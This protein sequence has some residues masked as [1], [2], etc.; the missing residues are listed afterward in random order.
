[1]GPALASKQKLKEAIQA[2]I[3]VARLNFSHGTHEDH[4]F[5]IQTIHELSRE[6][7]APV[8]LLQ[9]L[10]GP[11]IRLGK[12]HERVIQ[13]GETLRLVEVQQNKEDLFIDEPRLV[14]VL[15]AGDLILV[16][17]G[18]IQ[19]KVKELKKDHVA[20]EV[21]AGGE[22]KSRKGF[23]VPGR[24]LPMSSLTEKDK[25]DLQFG[26]D[27]QV[28][29][30]ALSFVRTAKDVLELREIIDRHE[31]S[32]RVIAKIEMAEAIDHLKEIIEVSDAIMVARG[33]LAIEVGSAR[34]PALQK[35]IIRQCNE[36]G[37]PVITA[38]QMLESM[39][40]AVTPTR[41]E[42]TDVANAVLDG[43]DALML[44]AES[45]SGDHPKK[46]IQTM[47][48]IILEA[49]KS[50][51]IYNKINVHRNLEHIP[52]AI[53][54]SSALCAHKLSAKAIVCLSTTGRTAR[55]ISRFRPQAQLIA[56]TDK[57]D[58]L[59]SLELCWGVQTLPIER[60]ES[61]EDIFAKLEPMLV[62]IG[63][64]EAGDLVVVTLG[65]PVKSG[66]KTNSMRVFAVAG[67]GVEK[68]ENTGLLRFGKHS[69]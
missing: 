38:T 19:L 56:A 26:L 10:Q 32:P 54:A 9:D 44:S 21:L 64:V 20:V 40:T 37:K 13:P 52:Q 30:V 39:R 51:E 68:E 11:K 35:E 50:P 46:A 62:E 43:S 24:P 36:A 67:D 6:L 22:L 7:G 47:H 65:T 53:A 12:I 25:K 29:H 69:S 28:D 61:L 48:E 27:N 8:S 2:G 34:L 55:M 45:A 33:D 60:Y 63:L 31:S 16:D 15:Q 1:M 23:S 42:I 49:E 14:T 66:V 59:R 4:S 5:F 58:T 18:L 17:D 57:V 3:N 41:A